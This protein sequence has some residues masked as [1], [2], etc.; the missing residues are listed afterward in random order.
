MAAAGEGVR[1]D[2]V[3]ESA[4]VGV[5]VDADRL[6]SGTQPMLFG[7]SK[8]LAGGLIIERFVHRKG[9]L[10]RPAGC[11]PRCCPADGVRWRAVDDRSPCFSA[12]LH[13]Q[14]HRCS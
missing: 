9:N 4:C 13:G 1:V 11:G 2:T 12:V 7:L 14:W 5:C 6:E 10:R 3:G 8:R